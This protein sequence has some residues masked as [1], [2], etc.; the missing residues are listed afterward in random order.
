[1]LFK[2]IILNNSYTHRHNCYYFILKEV[3]SFKYIFYVCFYFLLNTFVIYI[4]SPRLYQSLLF[5]LIEHMYLYNAV[6][7]IMLEKD[8]ID[9]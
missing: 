4:I 1:M 3:F 5:L 9:I 6:E 8:P 7:I 2:I